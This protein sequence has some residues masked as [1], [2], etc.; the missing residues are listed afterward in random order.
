MNRRICRRVIG[1]VA[2]VAT[3]AISATA[4]AQSTDFGFTLMTSSS[5]GL[6]QGSGGFT[7]GEPIP[8]TG[9]ASL[10]TSSFG[11]TIGTFNFSNSTP[12]FICINGPDPIA[13][14]AGPATV[15]FMDGIPTGISYYRFVTSSCQQ[16]TNQFFTLSISGDTFFYI[17]RDAG[18]DGS[19]SFTRPVPE[20][21][22]YALFA[23][24]LAALRLTAGR[25]A[26]RDAVIGRLSHSA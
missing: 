2:A 24:G 20:P 9:F 5:S 17:A 13:T 6:G 1:V 18:T 26:N 15:S 11:G 14:G 21:E 3:S 16:H 4:T 22:T 25:R 10:S 8:T 12:S 23:L 7:I 19:V